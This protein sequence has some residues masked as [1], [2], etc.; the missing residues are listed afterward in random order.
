M[1]NSLPQLVILVFSIVFH[2]VAHGKVALWRGDTT[3]RDAGRLTL[4]PLPHIDIF[5]TILLP[6]FL[7]LT[8]SPFLF[9]WAKPVPVNPWRL[10]EL[11]KDMALV[12]ASGPASNFLL[13]FIASVIFKLSVATLGLVNPLTRVMVFAV[14]INLVL[15]FFNLVPIPPL[16]GSRIVMGFLPDY[17]A[18]QYSRIERYGFL[19]IFGLL[20]LGFFRWVL[21][22]IV[23]QFLVLMVGREGIFLL[24]GG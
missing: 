17:L 20:F 21:W 12:G 1:I 11:K 6:L 8:R 19:I 18:V 3:A 9:G 14:T 16:D 24:F 5:G 4:N 23:F 2:E 13:A 10:R 15:A 7:I 22:P